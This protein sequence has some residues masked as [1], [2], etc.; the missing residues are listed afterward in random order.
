VLFVQRQKVPQ[1]L[2]QRF[3]HLAHERDLRVGGEKMHHTVALVRTGHINDRF[4]QLEGGGL[5]SST[6]KE[7]RVGMGRRANWSTP[8]SA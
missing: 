5:T 4:Q 7:G 3:A 2:D 1:L 8:S 6:S